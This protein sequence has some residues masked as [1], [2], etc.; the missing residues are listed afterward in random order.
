MPSSQRSLQMGKNHTGEVVADL[1]EEDYAHNTG[2]TD[3]DKPKK[4]SLVG[5]VYFGFDLTKLPAEKRP[6][7]APFEAVPSAKSKF[8]KLAYT[9]E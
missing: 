4:I 3:T 6:I 7:L 9:V 5:F 8:H 1:K 2:S